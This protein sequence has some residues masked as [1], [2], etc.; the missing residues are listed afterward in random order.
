M[1]S[2]SPHAGLPITDDDAAIAAALEDVSVPALLLSLV[3][4]TG[5]PSYIRGPIKPRMLILNEVQGFMPEEEKAEARAQ[6]LEAI[7]RYRD[8][9]CVLP[10]QPSPQLLHEMM[11]W[12][13][14][15]EIPAEYV[16]MMLED[17]Q[18]DGHEDTG[19]PAPG[20]AAT[21]EEFPVVVIGCGQSGLLAGIRLK[22]AGIPFTIVEKNAGV[23]GTWYENTYPGCR[24]DVGNHFYCYSF[25]PSDHWSE[26][27]ARQPELQR[28]FRHVM[29][30]HGIAENI[31]WRSEVASAVWDEPSATWQV[32][33][34]G[35]DGAAYTLAARAVISA[36]GL[37]NRP[38]IPA[39]DGAEGFTGPAF[40]SA[41]WDHSVDYRGKRVA[42]IGAGASGFQIG[43]TIAPDVAHLTVF[44]RT[45][46]WMFPNPNYHGRVGE[47]V[48]WAMRYL[49]F[50]ARWYRFMIFWP[51]G[52]GSLEGARIDP[53]WPHQ[54]R[55][56]SARNDQTRR[57]FTEWIT[58]QIGDD[59]ELLA[60]VLP[61]YPATG[62]R[63]LQDN[64]SWLHTLKRDNVTLVRDGIARIEKDAVVTADG[65]RHE[66]DII[67]Y[68]TGFQANRYLYPMHIVGRD[69]AVL[70]EQWGETPT[71]YLGITVPNFPN[72]FCMYGPGSALAHGGSLIFQSECQMRYIS[73]CL[74]HLITGGLRTMEPRQ[75]EHDAYVARH[76]AEIRQL[77]WSH[78]SIEHS[79]FK[80]ADGEVYTANPWR[81]VDYWNWTKDPRFDHYDI[82]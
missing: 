31:R 13:A 25:E 27:F 1:T 52:D 4:L 74:D 80:N 82:R 58:S 18:M 16:P 66:A 50:Y 6:A 49:P 12:V 47:G 60:K 76:R 59:P 55:S 68:A 14:C 7:R 78:P 11:N 64:G 71:A 44:Q 45:A 34:R 36:V 77:V 67:V 19:P 24:V 32:T 29:D 70:R 28:Y 79:Y 40:H 61:D 56:V 57:F 8:G 69:G 9:G 30:N 65:E 10:E 73:A 35:P 81:L 37:L 51:G 43:P 23:G 75:D 48:Q 62:K 42:M 41:R 26:F 20:D 5:D 46:Q 53:D 17:M 54:D 39:I 21:R 2:R 15:Q 38:N 22:E 3:H 72:L 63:T 33:V